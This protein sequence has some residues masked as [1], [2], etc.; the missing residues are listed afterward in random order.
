MLLPCGQKGGGF[1]VP[2]SH[3]PFSLLLSGESVSSATV[4]SNKPALPTG[5]VSCLKAPLPNNFEEKEKRSILWL[6]SFS[7]LYHLSIRSLLC[8]QLA[9]LTECLSF[10]AQEWQKWPY[11]HCCSLC[12]GS[13]KWG[14]VFFK[15]EHNE[16]LWRNDPSQITHQD[17]NLPLSKTLKAAKKHTEGRVCIFPPESIDSMDAEWCLFMSLSFVVI[18]VSQVQV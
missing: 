1:G 8:A 14:L 3:P 16:A 4:R 7:L 2:E 17:F 13:N 11:S 9:N 12:R 15:G 18:L 6:P 5:R 10:R